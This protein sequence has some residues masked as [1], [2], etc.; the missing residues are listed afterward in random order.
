MGRCPR[1]RAQARD[2]KEDWTPSRSDEFV[3]HIDGNKSNNDPSNL[4]IVDADTHYRHHMGPVKPKR[5]FVVQF[6][7]F[8]GDETWVKLR[9]PY[10]GNEFYRREGQ[11]FLSEGSKA[12]LTFCKALCKSRFMETRA[13]EL[14]DD[15]DRL[16]REN[17]VCKFKTNTDF[18]HVYLKKRGK[19]HLIDDDGVFHPPAKGYVHIQGH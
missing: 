2:G 13:E 18:M 4:T 5:R 7:P 1:P 16:R 9:C 14:R 11:T 15:L 6:P 19:R 12:Q 17:L 3:H 8:E 10:C